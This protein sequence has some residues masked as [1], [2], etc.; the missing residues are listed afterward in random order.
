VLE[1]RERL[2]TG[3]GVDLRHGLPHGLRLSRADNRAPRFGGFQLNPGERRPLDELVRNSP[4]LLVL[5][6][7]NQ[8]VFGLNAFWGGRIAI[9]EGYTRSAWG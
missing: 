4:N 3:D 6:A 1:Q 7:H 2:R 5:T 9:W 8:T